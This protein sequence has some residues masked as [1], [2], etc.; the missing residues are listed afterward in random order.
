M[1]KEKITKDTKEI[2]RITWSY[3]KTCT[4]Q[5]WKI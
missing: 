2:Q 1:K 3:F 5:N 4:S